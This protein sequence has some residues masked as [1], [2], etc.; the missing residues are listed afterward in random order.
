VF[1]KSFT[2]DI[3]EED[4]RYAVTS[5]WIIWVTCAAIGEDGPNKSVFKLFL[6]ALQFGLRIEFKSGLETAY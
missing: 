2:L 4:V 5:V 6:T 1:K 3:I